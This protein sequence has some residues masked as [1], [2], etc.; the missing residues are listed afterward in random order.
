PLVDSGRLHVS[1][2]A[3]APLAWLDGPGMAVDLGAVAKGRAAD[4]LVPLLT[5]SGVTSAILDLGGN[6]T[7]LGTRPD[8]TP[9]RIGVKDPRNTETYFC[10]LSLSDKTCSTSG[11]YE[12]K[13]EV[14]GTT[15][16]HILDPATGYPA[17]SGLLSVTAVSSDG[18]LADG[19]ST[20]CYVM[21]AEQSVRLWR[22]H[23]LEGAGFDLVLVRE[24]GSVWITEGVE[25]GLDFRGK[26]AGYTYEIIRR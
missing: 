13:F 9:W 16:H 18:M 19:L 15:Y 8:G 11:S 24:D 23:G 14:D 17:E 5:D 22:A 21:G 6:L 26:E 10:I 20:A 1:G 2:S 3:E 4:L 12:R 7:A 25:D